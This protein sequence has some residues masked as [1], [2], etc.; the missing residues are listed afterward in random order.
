MASIEKRRS[1]YRVRWRDPDGTPHNRQCP[2]I[3]TA[4]ELVRQVENAVALGRRWE[5]PAAVR[6]ASLVDSMATY[7]KRI[8]RVKAKQTCATRRSAL[9]RFRRFLVQREGKGRRLHWELLSRRTLE[10]WDADMV[11]VGL[12]AST[13]AQHLR[14]VM[15]FWNWA[16]DDDDL[17][18][19]VPRP[20]KIEAPQRVPKPVRAPTWAQMD[21]MIA[22]LDHE[23][24]RRCAMLMRYLGWRIGQVCRLEWPD[25]DLEAGTARLRGELGKSRA[26]K[27][28]RTVIMAPP[29]VEYLA[30]LGRREGKLVRMSTVWIHH[31]LVRAWEASGVDQE[32]WRR[33]SA[34]AFRRGFRTELKAARVDSEA[35]EFYCGRS[36]GVRDLYTDPRAHNLLELV[37]HIPP[38]GGPYDQGARVPLVSLDNQRRRKNG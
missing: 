7:I 15:H 1:G 3:T 8:G 5:A 14:N 6:V 27:V 26:E 17:G 23:E 21:A 10:E 36:T 16:Y 20:R 13:R 2:N 29:L 31:Y 11:E 30:T 18:P 38:V 33:R 24:P 25:F 37:D 4:R 34:H 22:K 19:H 9:E 28:G 32:V 35:I 12:Q